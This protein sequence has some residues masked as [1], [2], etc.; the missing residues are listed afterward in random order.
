MDD[1]KDGWFFF[2]SEESLDD[3]VFMV[4]VDDNDDD[5]FCLEMK[6]GCVSVLLFDYW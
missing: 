1:L 3:E 2:F 4:E 6:V 5:E